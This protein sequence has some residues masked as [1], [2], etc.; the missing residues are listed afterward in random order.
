MH[1]ELIFLI[2]STI[3]QFIVKKTVVFKSDSYSTCVVY[4]KTIIHLSVG[5]IVEYSC[6]AC[7]AD[8]L[9]LFQLIHFGHKIISGALIQDE[10]VFTLLMPPV[11]SV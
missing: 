6:T 10:S 11:L 3:C 1:A 5:E 4:T 2:I 8:V 7:I 9:N